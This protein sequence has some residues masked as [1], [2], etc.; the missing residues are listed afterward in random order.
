MIVPAYIQEGPR[1]R[2]A[3]AEN[4]TLP[5]TPGEGRLIVATHIQERTF[6]NQPT[7]QSPPRRR[8]IRIFAAGRQVKIDLSL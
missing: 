7:N 2:P 5:L 3:P 1:S 6:K 8:V 4:L